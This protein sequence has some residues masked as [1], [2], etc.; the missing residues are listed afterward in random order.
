LNI[1]QRY[2]EAFH[3]ILDEDLMNLYSSEETISFEKFPKDYNFI[4]LN[5]ETTVLYYLLKHFFNKKSLIS[6]SLWIPSPKTIPDITTRWERL[7]K[8]KD[9]RCFC[10][11]VIWENQISTELIQILQFLNFNLLNL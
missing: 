4:S 5:K 2:S 1:K 7:F 10:R 9:I 8:I 3:Q 11:I 6:R